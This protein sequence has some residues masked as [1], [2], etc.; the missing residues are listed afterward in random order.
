MRTVRY[1]TV[2]YGTV[3]YVRRYGTECVSVHTVLL[4]NVIVLIQAFCYVTKKNLKG[5]FLKCCC[6]LLIVKHGK[7]CESFMIACIKANVHSVFHFGRVRY[8][9]NTKEYCSL[10][11]NLREICRRIFFGIFYF[12]GGN[13]TF[14]KTLLFNINTTLT[15]FT[16]KTWFLGPPIRF[17]I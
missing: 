14:H 11:P 5:S 2:R 15:G 17:Y 6:K 16:A 9:T 10:D 12:F 7:D 8:G 13:F 1:G 3:R 4:W